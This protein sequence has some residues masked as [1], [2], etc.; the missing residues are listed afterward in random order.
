MNLQKPHL[1]N[2]HHDIAQIPQDHISIDLLGPYTITSQGNTYALTAVCNLT[3]YIMT[4]SII[5]KKTATVVIHL[6]SDILLKFS[7]PMIIH[8]A[9]RTEFKSKLIEHLTT[10]GIKRLISPLTIPK[11]T[12]NWNLP[13]DSPMT[14]LENFH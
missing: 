8:S 7:F 11:L 12:E 9:Y 14:V 4:L 13:M 3:C 6:F 5:D 10:V 2:L 1:I